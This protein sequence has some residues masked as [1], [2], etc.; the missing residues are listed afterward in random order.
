MN[1]LFFYL[2]Y[3]ELIGDNGNAKRLPRSCRVE[4]RRCS[5]GSVEKIMKRNKENKPP[6]NPFVQ[7]F[8]GA[9]QIL[10]S[11]TGQFWC[12]IVGQL[13]LNKKRLCRST[14]LLIN[15]MYT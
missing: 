10:G 2:S 9:F 1:E 3:P 4:T 11:S 15:C 6:K 7:L 14:V 13:V 8:V 12:I 5:D